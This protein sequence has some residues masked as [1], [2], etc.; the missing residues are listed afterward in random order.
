MSQR[1]GYLTRCHV[2]CCLHSRIVLFHW[3]I[4]Y[5]HRLF[6]FLTIFSYIGVKSEIISDVRKE[7]SKISYFFKNIV[8]LLKVTLYS[9]QYDTMQLLCRRVL[10]VMY[11][12][13]AKI[14]I[15]VMFHFWNNGHEWVKFI[16]NN[17]A[18]IFQYLLVSVYII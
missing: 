2:I 7:I 16:F 18:Y 14:F 6:I 15:K 3:Y 9:D 13:H 11:F 10:I 4:T 8:N 12:F 5:L 17:E 1:V